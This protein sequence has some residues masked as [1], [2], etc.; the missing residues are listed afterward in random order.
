M[1][2]NGSSIITSIDQTIRLMYLL[3]KYC[4]CQCQYCLKE[5]EFSVLVQVQSVRVQVDVNKSLGAVYFF[6]KRWGYKWKS[7]AVS[8]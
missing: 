6:T 2:M 7:S 8:E 5:T 3:Y 4:S 1:E